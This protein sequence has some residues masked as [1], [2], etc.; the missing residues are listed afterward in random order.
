MVAV[1]GV[2]LLVAHV[3]MLAP[4]AEVLTDE[5]AGVI[6]TGLGALAVAFRQAANGPAPVDKQDVDTPR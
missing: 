3:P 2:K 4:I 1:V 5:V 6:I